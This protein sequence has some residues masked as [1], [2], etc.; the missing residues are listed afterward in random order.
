MKTVVEEDHWQIIIQTVFTFKIL[1]YI[2]F[3][4]TDS[5]NRNIVTIFEQ[6]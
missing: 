4:L 2:T 1:D 6:L 3:T 5:F